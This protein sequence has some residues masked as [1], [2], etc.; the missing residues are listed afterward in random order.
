VPGLPMLVVISGPIASGKSTVAQALARQLERTG[1]QVAVIDLDLV[2]DTLQHTPGGAKDNNAAWSL[3]RRAAAAAANQCLA[4]GV[5][6]VIA[7]GSFNTLSQRRDFVERLTAGLAP[8]Y[9]TLLVS[10]EE[11]LRRAQRDPTRGMSRD[12]SFLRQYY[13]KVSAALGR[14]PVTD[15]VI[16]TELLTDEAAASAVA[17]RIQGG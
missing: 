2:H 3:A 13:A 17:R 4:K 5:A 9:V 1:V 11:A 10:C 12:P 15:I 8:I 6:V 7:E 14:L 16:D